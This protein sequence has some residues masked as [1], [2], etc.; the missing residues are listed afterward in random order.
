MFFTQI[1]CPISRHPS[2]TTVGAG[3]GCCAPTYLPIY[4]YSSYIAVYWMRAPDHLF[5]NEL[6]E[7]TVLKDSRAHIDL[8]LRRA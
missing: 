5:M 3:G 1:G 4:S 6:L 8:R 2:S 7:A